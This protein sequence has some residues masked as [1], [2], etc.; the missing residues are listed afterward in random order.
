VPLLFGTL[1]EP[2]RRRLLSPPKEEIVSEVSFVK[3]FIEPRK[4][5]L[6]MD[7]AL[8]EF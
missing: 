7:P 1:E 8:A 2:E 3:V 4:Y 6:P 5:Y